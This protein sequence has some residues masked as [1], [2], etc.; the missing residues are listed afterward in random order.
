MAGITTA[1]AIGASAVGGAMKSRAQQ[2]AANAAAAGAQFSPWNIGGAGGNIN[3]NNG[4]ISAGLDPNQQMMQNVF[5]NMFGNIAAGGGFNQEAAMAAS[6]MGTQALP[7][8]FQGAM[9]ASQQI[10]VDAV[11]AFTQNAMNNAQFGQGFGMNA[12]AQAAQFGGQQTGLNEGLAQ[13]L[14]SRAQG[15]MDQQF[16]DVRDAQLANARAL[17]RPGEERAVNAKFQN[18]FNRGVLSQT[19]GERQIGELALAQEQADIQRQFGAEQFANQLTQQNRQFAGNLL[20]QGL[21]GRQMDQSFNLGAGGLFAN[22]GQGM[23]QFG[24]GQAGA[25]LG[26]QMSLSDMINTRGQQRLA[27]TQNLLGFG[28]NINQSNI[29]QMLSMFG[30]QSQQNADL[31]NLMALGIN[32]GGQQA[33]GGAA[34]GNLMMQGAGS[35]M[36]SFLGGLGA[37]LMPG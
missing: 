11:N 1:L 21:Q 33:A 3:F 17:A 30:A 14:F 13:G 29:N 35:P 16:T 15:L 32:A 24:A 18:L 36:G 10:P 25:G 2:K 12:L 26:A 8:V 22:M 9:D 34:A 37:G 23:M 5:Q 4:K 6:Q 27:N 7:S 28:Q 20:G 31:R 19:G